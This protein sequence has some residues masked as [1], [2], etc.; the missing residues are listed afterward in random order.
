MQVCNISFQIEPQVENEWF[1]WMQQVFIPQLM[2]SNCFDHYQ[3]Y[4]LEVDAS[5]APTY[6]LQAYAKSPILLEGYRN[7]HAARLMYN[8]H[9]TWGEQCFQFSSYMKKRI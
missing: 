1:A 7:Q 3:F 6:T 2:E 9:N 8:L 5:Q 4:Q